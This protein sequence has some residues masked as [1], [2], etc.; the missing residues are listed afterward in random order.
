M[1]GKTG[2]IVKQLLQVGIRFFSKGLKRS[3]CNHHPVIKQD[4]A[5]GQFLD[6]IENM[7]GI[8]NC[9]AAVAQVL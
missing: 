8:K 2:Q 7:A 5:I 9:L 4:D 1:L 6:N 3:I